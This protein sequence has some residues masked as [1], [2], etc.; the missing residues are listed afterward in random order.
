MKPTLETSSQTAHELEIEIERVT[1]RASNS[2]AYFHIGLTLLAIGG[3]VA[4]LAFTVLLSPA[5]MLV[6]KET[7]G[8]PE[9]QVMIDG[10]TEISYIFGNISI[11]VLAVG[12]AGLMY[13]IWSMGRN[14][15]RAAR[16]QLE[17]A[18]T[19]SATLRDAN[20][21]KPKPHRILKRKN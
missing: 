5:P 11:V 15:S 8:L 19:I 3:T 21:P 13:G 18:R 20:S 10:L 16:I 1:D 6:D 12:V 4:V 2:R 9:T 7:A 17:H 14:E